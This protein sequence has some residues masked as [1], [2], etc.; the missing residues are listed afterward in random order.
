MDSIYNICSRVCN[1]VNCT[2]SIVGAL[3][4]ELTCAFVADLA[5]KA[6]A[7]YT[8]LT[9]NNTLRLVMDTLGVIIAVAVVIMAMLVSLTVVAIIVTLLL[10]PNK[11][12]DGVQ[13]P[14]VIYSA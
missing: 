2:V 6:R 5:R 3:V 9:N 11:R 14:Y 13:G 8:S 1:F 12:L 4:V 7:A 10:L